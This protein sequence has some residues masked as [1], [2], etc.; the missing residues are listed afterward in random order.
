MNASISPIQ[1]IEANNK[2]LAELELERTT[3][4]VRAIAWAIAKD[5]GMDKPEQ[6]MG[7]AEQ[8]VEQMR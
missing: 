3:H 6:A 5:S 8:I 4:L 1:K 2:R 7:Q